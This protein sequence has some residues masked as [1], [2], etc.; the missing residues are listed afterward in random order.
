MK[1]EARLFLGAS[2]F[3]TVS[4]I[5]YW[6]WSREQAGTVWFIFGTCACLMV[7]GFLYLQWHRRQGIPRPE[8]NEYAEQSDGAGEI[9]F[10][11]AASMWPPAMGAGAVF[12]AVGTIYGTWYWVIGG[13]LMLGAIIGYLV[14]A[15]AREDGPDDP[16]RPVDPTV[17]AARDTAEPTVTAPGAGS[18]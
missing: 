5:V 1:L 12:I 17:P 18:H 14:E 3:L 16:G 10:F 11:P 13:V 8:D 2:V 6:F 4:A 7:S 9:G 15:E